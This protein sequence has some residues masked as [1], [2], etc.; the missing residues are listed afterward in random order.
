MPLMLQNGVLRESMWQD[1]TQSSAHVPV[2]D[3]ASVEIGISNLRRQPFSPD[4]PETLEL[5]ERDSSR[6]CKSK[7]AR[8]LSNVFSP[9]F[10]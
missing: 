3:L 9:C 2:M 4:Q 5:G 7:L 8:H 1:R 6:F 10:P